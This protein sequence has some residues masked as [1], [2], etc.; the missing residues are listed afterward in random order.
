ML[1]K[2]ARFQL[3]DQGVWV[4]ELACGHRQHMR[5]NP[6]WQERHWTTTEAGRASMVGAEL[7][8]VS[9]NMGR[10]P[11]GLVSYRRTATF[12][13]GTVPEAL[14]RDHQTK[15]GTWAQ[16]VVEE[17]KLEYTCPRGTF[18][19]NPSIVGVIEPAVSH[20][21]RVIGPARFHLLFFQLPS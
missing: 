17:G 6:P 9:C 2:V 20:R 8:C 15:P 13:E 12:S 19:L 14:L 11:D 5:H 4:A 10:L 7:D 1:A 18:F 3:D 16:I 21:V